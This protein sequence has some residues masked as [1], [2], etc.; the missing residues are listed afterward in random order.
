LGL[1]EKRGPLIMT[2]AFASGSKRLFA[3][4]LGNWH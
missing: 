3:P 4:A 1:Q 2:W